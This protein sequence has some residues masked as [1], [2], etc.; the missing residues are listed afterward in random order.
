[1]KTI[2]KLLKQTKIINYISSAIAVVAFILTA[3]FL[4]QNNDLWYK[5]F[6]A[7]G[8]LSLDLASNAYGYNLGMTTATN[9]L[10]ER[11]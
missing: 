9:L 5:I 2:E 6:L 3:V 10:T 4:K 1:M 8:I 7:V 11:K